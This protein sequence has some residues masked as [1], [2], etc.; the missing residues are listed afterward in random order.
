MEIGALETVMEERG[1]VGWVWGVQ[2]EQ[3]QLKVA[4]GET[5][6]RAGRAKA[7]RLAWGLP[8]CVT[9]ALSVCT[10]K[11]PLVCRR[12]H[13]WGSLGPPLLPISA[14]PRETSLMAHPQ[15]PCPGAPRD[16]CSIPYSH[17]QGLSCSRTGHMLPHHR[18]APAHP[19]TPKHDCTAAQ[20][21]TD[22]SAML[23]AHFTQP[24]TVWLPLEPLDLILLRAC[25]APWWPLPKPLPFGR[26]QT[27]HSLQGLCRW[28]VAQSC[29]TLCDPMDC[30]TPGFP[31]H[32]HLPELAQTHVH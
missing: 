9:K 23:R 32:Q 7:C 2:L 25:P 26:T 5:L 3:H 4:G 15:P 28:S 14:P 22:M 20:H 24:H 18:R 8:L 10:L 30:S 16:S 13:R 17:A 11:D 21:H 29:P 19:A 31:V 6:E 27:V 12:G 1:A